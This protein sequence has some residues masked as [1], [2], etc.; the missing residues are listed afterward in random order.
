MKQLPKRVTL[1]PELEVLA[2]EWNP[3]M[4]RVVARKFIRWARQ[5]RVSARIMMLDASYRPAK[6]LRHVS[7]VKAKRN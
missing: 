4:R 6:R 5:L 7:P 1:E 3:E 2:R